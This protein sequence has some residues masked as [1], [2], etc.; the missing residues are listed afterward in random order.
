MDCVPEDAT[1]GHFVVKVITS[2]LDWDGLR[3]GLRAGSPVSYSIVSQ[4]RDV[5]VVVVVV[6]YVIMYNKH[7]VVSLPFNC[8]FVC[9]LVFFVYVFCLLLS[10]NLIIN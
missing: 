5:S 8:Q 1:L 10:C 7:H 4:T 3:P 6:V 9:G 2:D